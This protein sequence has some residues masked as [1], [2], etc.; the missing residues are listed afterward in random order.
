MSS[1]HS[2]SLQES[3]ASAHRSRY[4]CLTNQTTCS[5]TVLQSIDSRPFEDIQFTAFVLAYTHITIILHRH[6]S[7]DNTSSIFFNLILKKTEFVSSITPQQMNRLCDS[8][9]SPLN[10]PLAATEI[11]EDAICFAVFSVTRVL[12][13]LAFTSRSAQRSVSINASTCEMNASSTHTW[14]FLKTQLFAC[15]DGIF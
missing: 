10:M 4:K 5:D 2:V 12:T 13:P 6:T 1:T 8:D 15:A 11:P 7:E 14:V 3:R 9:V